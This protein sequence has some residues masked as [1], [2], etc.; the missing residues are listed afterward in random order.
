METEQDP[1]HGKQRAEECEAQ[2]EWEQEHLSERQLAEQEQA[3]L[4]ERG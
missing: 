4:I 2:L 3:E 1:A